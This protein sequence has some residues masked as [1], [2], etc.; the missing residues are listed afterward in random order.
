MLELGICDDQ[1]PVASG[2][3][4]IASK[5]ENQIANLVPAFCRGTMRSRRAAKANITVPSASDST[6]RRAEY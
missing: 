3:N 1:M 5:A 4:P 6:I 2:A